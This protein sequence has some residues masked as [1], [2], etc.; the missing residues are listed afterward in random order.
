[1]PSLGKTSITDLGGGLYK[2][3]SFFDV[4]TELSIDGGATWTP[5][6]GPPVH[7][8]LGGPVPEPTALGLLGLSLLGAMRRS[9]RQV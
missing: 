4:F 2:I 5:S 8:E 3:D 1:M 6:V 7:F 9:R